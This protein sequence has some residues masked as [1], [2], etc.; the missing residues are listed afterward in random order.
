M[1]K[2]KSAYLSGCP[3]A[4]ALDLLGDRWTLLIVR[5]LMFKD[6]RTYGEFLGA[7]E[8]IATNILADRLKRLEKA[9]IV[10]K[11]CDQK[12]RT[13]Y[14]YQLTPKGI[15]LTP[16]MLELIEWS[17]TYDSKT[18]APGSFIKRLKKDKEGIREEIESRLTE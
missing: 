16:V 7:G 12:N 8:G 10:K 6:K 17:V 13:K 4:F 2:K 1:V 18:G 9:K 11:S 15:A 5:D 14:I 3:I